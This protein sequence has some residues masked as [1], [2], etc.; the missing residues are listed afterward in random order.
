MRVAF[1]TEK[2]VKQVSNAAKNEAERNLWKLFQAGDH[3]A[4]AAIYQSYVQVIYNYCRKFSDDE[5]LIEDCIHGL[6]LDMWKNRENLSVPTS[7]RYYL[8]ASVKRRIYKEVLKRKD[9]LFDDYTHLEA[10][11]KETGATAEEKIINSQGKAQQK[12]SLK[13]GLLLLS[14]NQRKAILLKFYKNLS[15]QEISAVMNLSTDNI[16]K[17]VSRG[18]AV[19]KKNVKNL[20]VSY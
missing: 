1:Q 2:E 14:E 9:V 3:D 20:N 8:Y 11:L 17:L 15:F 6:F 10:A 16:Y 13:Q 18:I 12:A 19:L 5:V 7:I 4:F